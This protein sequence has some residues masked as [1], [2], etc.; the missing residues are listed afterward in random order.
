MNVI[1]VEGGK[2]IFNWAGEVEPGALEQAQ[3]LA[4]LPFV[5]DHVALMPDAHQGYGMPIGGVLFADDAIVPYAV[6]VDIGCGVTLLETDLSLLDDR[7]TPATITTFLAQIARDVPV[8]NGPG[9]GHRSPTGEPFDIPG[10]PTDAAR[11][12][13]RDGDLQLGSLGGGNHFLE[14]QSDETGHLWFMIHSGSRSVGKKICDYHHHIALEFAARWYL[15][16]VNKELAWLP[17]DTDEARD[18][19]EDMSAAL[20]WAEENRRRMSSAVISA[21]GKVFGAS[22][23]WSLDIHHNYAAHETH[24]GQK[25]IIHRKGAVRAKR[26]EIVLIPGSMSTGSYVALGRGNPTSF[27]SCQHGAGR[28]RS[29]G[30]TRKL[31]TLDQMEKQLLLANVILVTPSRDKV[32]DESQAAYKDIEDVMNTSTDLVTGA[33]LHRPVGVVKG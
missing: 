6:G 26:M 22:A 30:A 9:G 21:F 20:L 11:Q 3:N 10:V 16:L 5:I 28:A 23:W 29:R 1:Q 8:G 13:I 31:V 4:R 15:P 7:V 18:Y 2:P 25:G 12:I 17:W 32:I 14:L 24:F 27:E 33:R 19:W